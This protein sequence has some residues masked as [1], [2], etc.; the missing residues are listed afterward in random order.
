MGQKARVLITVMTY[1]MPSVTYREL[2][3]TGGVREDGSFIR[4]YPIDYRYNPPWEWYR[5]Y[6]WIELDIEK[7]VK[8]IR[9][10]SFRP[11]PNAKIEILGPP[12]STKDNWCARK[13]Y[14]FAKGTKTMCGLN[15]VSQEI[16]SMGIVGVREAI[17]FKAQPTSRDWKPA[18]K[19][20]FMQRTLFGPDQKPLE[21]VPYKFSYVYKCYEPSCPGHNMM[22]ED[23]EIGLLYRRMR[24]KFQDEKIAVQKVKETFLDRI[25]AP[26]VDTHFYVGTILKHG[27]W[28]VI[29]TF[30]P[31]KQP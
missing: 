19:R 27:T 31:K 20:L 10:E 22:I 4:L 12:L 26:D 17:D 18:W 11:T 13:R 25:C 14:V 8:D 1:P 30:W 9:P 3:C 5:K 16:C 29:G 6:Q 21:K 23:W 15:G 28:V 2:V 24:D 7:N